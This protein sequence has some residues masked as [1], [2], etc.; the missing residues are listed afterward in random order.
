[1]VLKVKSFGNQLVYQ[2]VAIWDIFTK[3]LAIMVL[4]VQSFGNQLVY[5]IVVIW[6]KSFSVAIFMSEIINC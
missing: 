6:E 3:P 5:L 4:K 1:M 2:I